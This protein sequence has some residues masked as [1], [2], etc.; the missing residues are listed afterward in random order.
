MV[1]ISIAALSFLAQCTCKHCV[2]CRNSRKY[3]LWRHTWLLS[4]Q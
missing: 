1:N 3:V 2:T 4:A